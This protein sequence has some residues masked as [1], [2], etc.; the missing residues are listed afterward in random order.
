MAGGR[1]RAPFQARTRY[2]IIRFTGL[3]GAQVDQRNPHSDV[4]TARRIITLLGHTIAPAL[5]VHTSATPYA[6]VTRANVER[7]ATRRLRYSKRSLNRSG[8]GHRRGSPMRRIAYGVDRL[9]PAQVGRQ[10]K[11]RARH[12]RHTTARRTIK[13]TV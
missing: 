13:T 12:A 1:W 10:T 11:R 8:L 4:S 2:E 6:P 9:G 5:R 7:R 3:E